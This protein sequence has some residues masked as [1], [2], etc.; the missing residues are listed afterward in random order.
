MKG[1]KGRTVICI[2]RAPTPGPRVVD[3]PSQARSTHG[4]IMRAANR[5]SDWETHQD[6]A[7]LRIELRQVGLEVLTVHSGDQFPAVEQHDKN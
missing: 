5:R 6:F 4:M 7:V 3:V 2:G 1:R